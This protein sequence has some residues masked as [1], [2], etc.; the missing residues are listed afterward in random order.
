M[1]CFS[2]V[3]AHVPGH[4]AL[5]PLRTIM[6][7]LNDLIQQTPVSKSTRTHLLERLW[8][9]ATSQLECET[10]DFDA[11]FAYHTKQC[12]QA[13]HD[14]GQHICVCTHW[15]ITEVAGDIKGGL[16]RQAIK[17]RL[18]SR[19]SAPRPANEDELLDNSIDLTARLVSMMG[20]GVLRY[21]FSGRKELV[22]S[23][24]NLQNFIHEH[25]DAPI[26]LTHENIRLEKMFNARSLGRT[27]GIQIEWTDNLADHLRITDDNDKRVAIFRHASFLK[28]TQR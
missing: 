3:A 12:I 26:V 4:T 11:Y 27:A 24:G 7:S 17:S 14:D 13:L 18:S 23:Q 20:I 8:I 9:N 19:L 5:K 21:G 10:L 25:F 16:T 15:D 28:Y 2:A 1:C 22:W 6:A